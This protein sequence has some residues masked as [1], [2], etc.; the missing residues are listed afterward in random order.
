[1]LITTLL[2]SAL[3]SSTEGLSFQHKDWELACDNTRTCR[4]AGY[5][6]ESGGLSV[7]LTQPQTTSPARSPSR[8]NRA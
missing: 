2:A 3:G 8:S 7:L 6:A 1:M 4:A 5:S